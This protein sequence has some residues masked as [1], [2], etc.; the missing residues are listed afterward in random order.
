MVLQDKIKKNKKKVPGRNV[1][2]KN[3][4]P[5][6]NKK[7][8][9]GEKKTSKKVQQSDKKVVLCHVFVFFIYVHVT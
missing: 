6:P 2:K 4:T 8:N 7:A 5:H 9:K 3:P 1:M